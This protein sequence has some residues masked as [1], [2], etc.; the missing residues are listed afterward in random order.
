VPLLR[1]KGFILR[2][3]PLGETDRLITCFT[4]EQGKIAGV[5]KGA[6]R[7]RSRFGSSL[8]P[9]SLLRLML[10]GKETRSLYRIDHTD[11]LTS[12][13]VIRD[14]WEKLRPALYA[15]D[16][17]D[18]L[19]ADADPQ[20]RVFT[21][22]ERLLTCIATGEQMHVEV[23]LRLFEARLLKLVGYQPLLERCISCHRPAAA[24]GA[25]SGGLGGYVCPSCAPGVA[26]ARRV[27]PA[28]LRLLARASTLQWGAAER[29][30][31]SGEQQQEL[32][33]ALHELLRGHVRKEVKS[34]RFLSE[35]FNV[36][37]TLSGSQPSHVKEGL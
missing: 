10:F 33:Q 7:L 15:V 35:Q 3:R 23:W 32:R 6:G 12:F 30:C 36:E 18:A 20:P 13:Q 4:L 2:N 1:A 8:Q 14:D 28:T 9:L 37:S 22:L 19:L 11:I 17:V 29:L 31:L 21:L 24:A 16:L 26:D 25:L 34:Y 27:S 5:A